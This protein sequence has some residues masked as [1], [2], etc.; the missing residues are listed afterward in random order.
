[1]IAENVFRMNQAVACSG[2]I[3]LIKRI[4]MLALRYIQLIIS[5]NALRL[6]NG[7]SNLLIL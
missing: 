7:P 5:R 3:H 6:C 1:M 2:L 4:I